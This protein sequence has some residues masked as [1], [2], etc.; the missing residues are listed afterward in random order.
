MK[1]P[2]FLLKLATVAS[3]VLLVGGFVAYR[4]DALNW[5]LQTSATAEPATSPSPVEPTGFQA[6]PPA[7]ALTD[8]AYMSSSK[9][10][11]FLPAP[12]PNT[13]GTPPP[14]TSQSSKPPQ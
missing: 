10:I 3:S 8:P 13:P 11:I 2:R 12:P 5:V 9:S 1:Y 6:S 14:S 7:G 4:A